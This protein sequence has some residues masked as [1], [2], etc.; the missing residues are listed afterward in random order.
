M[1]ST[2]PLENGPLP[3]LEQ[4]T[5]CLSSR[6]DRVYNNGRQQIELSVLLAP[7]DDSTVTTLQCDSIGLAYQTAQGDWVPLSTQS[8]QHGWFYTA[9]HDDRYDYYPAIA[10]L[11]VP[12]EVP[13]KAHLKRLY[14]HSLAAPGQ[15][16]T[17]RAYLSLASGECIYSNS[18]FAV[19]LYTEA[20]PTYVFPQDYRWQP[21]NRVHDRLFE[22]D[23]ERSD[24]FVCEYSLRPLHVEFSSARLS[25]A[26]PAFEHLLRWDTAP[27]NNGATLVSVVPPNSTTVA[28]APELNALTELNSRLVEEVLSSTEGQ[29]IVLMQGAPQVPRAVIESVAQPPLE[30][31]AIDRYGALHRLAVDFATAEDRFA[32][33]AFTRPA[34]VQHDIANITYFRVAGR[35]MSHDAASCKLYNNGYQQTYVTV[36]LEAEDSVGQIVDV[37][38]SVL[39]SITLVNYEDGRPLPGSYTF[40]RVQSETDRRFDYYPNQFKDAQPSADL[41]RSQSFRL[42]IKTSNPLNIRVAAR[43]AI[44]MKTY[45]THDKTLPAGEGKTSSGR[46]NTSAIIEPKAQDYH[47]DRQEDYELKRFDSSDPLDFFVRD[48][49]RWELKFG[50]HTNHRIAYFATNGLALWDYIGEGTTNWIQLFPITRSRNV[51]ANRLHVSQTMSK[52]S[53]SYCLARIKARAYWREGEYNGNMKYWATVYDEMGNSHKVTVRTMD[54]MNLLRL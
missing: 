17:L 27:E 4:L 39:D 29:L 16:L 46:S 26:P 28:Y 38:E 23:I 54:N 49:D 37:P 19:T 30:L 25:S 5:M 33:T 9:E 13:S 14:V 22:Q 35:G 34:P 51:T 48:L 47:F 10:N 45:H 3:V 36:T 53:D 8:E 43:L 7:G 31:E 20:S 50:P 2:P 52:N 18:E 44:G 42:F 15:S 12:I 21:H 1:T 24:R 32:M 6:S 11:A 41:P 40:S